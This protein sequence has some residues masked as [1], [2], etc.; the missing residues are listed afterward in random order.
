MNTARR[1]WLSIHL[2][3]G[4]ALG[5]LLV[6]LGLTGSALVFY[7]EIDRWLN[8]QIA[9]QADSPAKP[10]IDRVL[11][12]LR[13][14][15]P[16]RDGPWRIELPQSPELP[17]TARYYAPIERADRAFAPLMVTVDPLTFAVS[18]ERFWGDTAMTW[19]Y[20]LHYTLLLDRPGKIAV[21]IAGLLSL[22]SIGSGLWLW[23]PRR[24]RFMRALK[25]VLRRGSARLTYDLHVLSG[26]WGAILL[27]LMAVT[28]AALAL[29]DQTRSLIDPASPLFRA[30]DLHG[31]APAGDA[32][33]GAARVIDIA[34]RH[35]PGTEL[36]WV[37]SPALYGGAWRI[38][39]HQAGE[40]SHR[41]PRTQVWVHPGTGEV[42]AERNTLNDGGG[43]VL[44]NWLHP[45]H[46]GEAFGMTGRLLAFIAGLLP[47]VLFAT[48]WLRWRRKKKA[49]AVAARLRTAHPVTPGRA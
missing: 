4:L 32:G 47:A 48:G 38:V 29:P 6:V 11:H 35:F 43:D 25:P 36:R 34:Q 16:Q 20:D 19:I 15:Q 1:L 46:N 13:V 22:L 42:L 33:I 9:V 28:G 18:S 45:L 30:P 31:I 3:L 44:L 27:V 37:E 14:S 7:L 8:P 12:A 5:G 17:V 10:D 24:G 2:W 49:Q 39:L 23:W 26:T 40:P 41:F 21:G